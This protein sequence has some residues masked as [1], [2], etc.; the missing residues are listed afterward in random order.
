MGSDKHSIEPH[1][2]IEQ[3]ETL[4]ARLDSFALFSSVIEALKDNKCLMLYSLQWFTSPEILPCHF[5][6]SLFG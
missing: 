4:P 3:E 2:K 5:L 6:R 1:R